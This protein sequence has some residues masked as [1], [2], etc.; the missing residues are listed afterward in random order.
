MS[1]MIYDSPHT[2]MP[3]KLV[4]Q[5]SIPVLIALCPLFV[6]FCGLIRNWKVRPSL[7]VRLHQHLHSKNPLGCAHTSCT[8]RE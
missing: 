5:S 6:E 4:Q 3:R 8:A 2:V 1:T 7:A